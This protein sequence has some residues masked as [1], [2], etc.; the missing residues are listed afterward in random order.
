MILLLQLFVKLLLLLLR[1]D[2]FVEVF[3]SFVVALI[4]EVNLHVFQRSAALP[5]RG[6]SDHEDELVEEVDETG[7]CFWL[8]WNGPFTH[9]E[10]LA[11]SRDRKLLQTRWLATVPES[12]DARENLN[13]VVVFKIEAMVSNGENFV[14]ERLV[15]EQDG[16]E[17]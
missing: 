8:K 1:T 15:L 7:H 17:A 4:D 12:E 9:F 5:F 6:A 16:A 13:R 14:V 2:R 10:H 3:L 11:Q